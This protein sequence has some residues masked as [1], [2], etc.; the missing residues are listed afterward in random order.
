MADANNQGWKVFRPDW[1]NKRIIETYISSPTIDKQGDEVPVATIKEAMENYM[2]FGIYSYKHE[3]MPIGLPLAYKVKGGKI[4]IRV[5]I[6]NKMDMHDRV[7]K[8][9]QNYG[10]QGASSIRGE[11]IDT[12]KVC[13]DRNVCH[14]RINDLNLWSVSWV[15]NTPANPEAKVTSV[16][17]A[18]E[19]TE[20]IETM[21]EKII[22]KRGKQYCLLARKDRK[23]LGCHSSKEGAMK[24]ERAIQARRFGKALGEADRAIKRV[25]DKRLSKSIRLNSMRLDY[26]L[27]KAPKARGG[28]GKKKPGKG[29]P[30]KTWFENCR[31]NARKLRYYSKLPQ[32]F[33]ERRFCAELWRNPGKFHGRGPQFTASRV[34]DRSGYKLRDRIGT[35]GWKPA[36]QAYRGQKPS[37]F[38]SGKR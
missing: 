9:I 14:N 7:W 15:G 36:R 27:E 34:R 11:A 20:E 22:V 28:K 23:L 24:Q 32:V 33:D 25:R 1:Y 5:G 18:K 13:N 17:V 31:M 37:A 16:S 29:R 3:E 38:G 4:K 19:L 26:L 2:K 12:E 21:V 35:S 6:H 8:E 10:T 30:P